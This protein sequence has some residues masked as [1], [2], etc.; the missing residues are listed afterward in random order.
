MRSVI[1]YKLISKWIDLESPLDS[2]EI[3]SVNPKGNQSW[4]FIERTDAEAE[5]PILWLPDGKNWLI[6]KDLDAGKDWGHE[7]KGTTEDEM[8][9]WHHRLNGHEF[10]INSRSWWMHREAWRIAVQ[11]S[12]R[13]RHDL[14]T[15]L[16][17][18]VSLKFYSCSILCIQMH[19]KNYEIFSKTPLPLVLLSKRKGKTFM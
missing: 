3:Q 8:A 14:A 16:N 19:F 17:W 10:W 4:V 12:Q 7:E 1:I 9:G 11:G 6:W 2:K 15:E 13:V 5:T 18:F